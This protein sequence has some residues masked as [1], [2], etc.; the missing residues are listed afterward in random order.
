MRKY[1]S[2]RASLEAADSAIEPK[3]VI[4]ITNKELAPEVIAHIRELP[5]QFKLAIVFDPSGP[6][7][8]M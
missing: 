4:C 1:G 3:A 2:V 8:N 7:E 5:E 6:I